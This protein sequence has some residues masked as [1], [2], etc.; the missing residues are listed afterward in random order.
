MERLMDGDRFYYLYRLFLALPEIT[1]LSGQVTNEQ[2]K[3]IVERTTG[4]TH[5]NGDIM[6]YADSYVEL[7][8]NA[9]ADAASE[10]KYGAILDSL[11]TSG[12]LA[13]TQGVYSSGGASTGGNGQLITIAD[14]EHPGQFLTF[15][16][17]V[18]P[19]SPEINSNGNPDL[20]L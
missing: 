20:R 14:P 12:G 15:I 18:R 3:D 4:V 19:D 5:L 9:T 17:D 11:H 7:G 13:A 6:L 1:N 2:F 16:N 8:H 10:H